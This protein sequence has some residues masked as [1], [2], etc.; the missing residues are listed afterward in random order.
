[1]GRGGR[2]LP[3]CQLPWL[4]ENQAQWTRS[5]KYYNFNLPAPRA[6][7]CFPSTTCTMRM[8][9]WAVLSNSSGCSPFKGKLGREWGGGGAGKKNPNTSSNRWSLKISLDKVMEEVTAA[10]LFGGTQQSS[11]HLAFVLSTEETFFFFLNKAWAESPLF[12][13][14]C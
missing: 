8:S 3:F 9:P 6:G 12:F 5:W 2:V 11:F 1:M 13:R 7:S 10:G 4:P 14:R